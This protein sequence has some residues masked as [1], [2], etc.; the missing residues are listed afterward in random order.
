[1]LSHPVYTESGVC[2]YGDIQRLEE[3]LNGKV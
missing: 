3:L 2:P 1:M